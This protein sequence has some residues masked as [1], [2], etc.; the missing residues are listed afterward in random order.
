ML[1]VRTSPTLNGQ[2]NRIVPGPISLQRFHFLPNLRL[3][4]SGQVAEAWAATSRVTRPFPVRRLD[5]R[6]ARRD[7]SVRHVRPS[8]RGRGLGAGEFDDAKIVHGGPNAGK[9]M[10]EEMAALSCRRHVNYT[11]GAHAEMPAKSPPNQVCDLSSASPQQP[12]YKHLATTIVKLLFRH[13]PD[14][15]APTPLSNVWSFKNPLRQDWPRSR[16]A[17]LSQLFQVHGRR[18]ASSSQETH[19]SLSRRVCANLPSAKNKHSTLQDEYNDH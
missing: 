9:Q 2:R 10:L 3:L 19:G 5:A 11:V 4:S 16:R 7:S 8:W 12:R 6:R 17:H 14:R 18:Y 13:H 15:P 1:G